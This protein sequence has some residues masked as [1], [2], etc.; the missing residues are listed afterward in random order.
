MVIVDGYN[1]IGSVPDGWWRDRP[2]AVRRLLSRLVCHRQQ[3]GVEV[4]LVLDVVQQDLPAGDHDG[5]EVCY[6]RRPSRNAADG[7]ILELLEG[8]HPDE[9]VEVV[10]SDRALALSAAERGAS[11]IGSRTFLAALDELGC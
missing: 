2:A 5:V 11:I 7:K 4:V 1:V 3:A 9:G 6:P 8:E 10:T